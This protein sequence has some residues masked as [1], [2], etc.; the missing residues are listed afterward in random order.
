MKKQ[1]TLKQTSSNNGDRDAQ[2]SLSK[3]INATI[4]ISLIV[5]MFFITWVP[6]QVLYLVTV[7]GKDFMQICSYVIWI[8]HFNSAINP[9]LYAYR[10]KDIRLAILK[11]FGAGSSL[12]YSSSS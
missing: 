8:A 12:K 1:V 11:L 7:L 9:L 4:N 3:E 6:L 10:M 5:L 2:K